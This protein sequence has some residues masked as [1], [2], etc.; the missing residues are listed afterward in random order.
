MSTEPANEQTMHMMYDVNYIYNNSYIGMQKCS[1][2]NIIKRNSRFYGIEEYVY[3]RIRTERQN[4]DIKITQNILDVNGISEDILFKRALENSNKETIVEQLDETLGKIDGRVVTDTG[5]FY[6]SNNIRYKG[7][8]AILNFD[9]LREIAEKLNVTALIAMPT[10]IH[11]FLIMPCYGDEEFDI[12][13]CSA[14]IRETNN[15]IVRENEIL[16]DNAYVIRI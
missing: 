14:A 11:E 5:L 12:E 4:G 8:S 7:A 6:L 15:E 1:D 10:S 2:E 9:K 3:V 16:G 13:K